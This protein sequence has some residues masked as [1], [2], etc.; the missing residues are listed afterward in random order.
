MRLPSESG[1][2]IKVSGGRTSGP[3]PTSSGSA[4]L[5]QDANENRP[6]HNVLYAASIPRTVIRAETR[7]TSCGAILAIAVVGDAEGGSDRLEQSLAA[8][9]G[10]GSVETVDVTLV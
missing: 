7:C 1:A 4:Q 2:R 3:G 5:F 6:V 10:V 8:L 9:P